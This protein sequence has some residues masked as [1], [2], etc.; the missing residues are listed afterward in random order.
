MPESISGD[1]ITIALASDKNYADGLLVTAG[2]I[3]KRANPQAKIEWVVLDG[4]ILAE[5]VELLEKVVLERH[6][7]S[8]FRRIPF[9]AETIP[10]REYH[11]SV[12]SY[13]RLYLP[14]LLP[15][16]EW[17]LY[18][19]VDFLWL[20][21]V[22]E[23]WKLRDC[24]YCVQSTVDENVLHDGGGGEKEWFESRG[25]RF[26][27]ENYFCAGLTLFNLKKLRETGLNA[28]FFAFLK[29]NQDVILADQSVMNAV[30]PP[31]GIGFLPRRWQIFANRL[32]SSDASGQFVIHYGASA[33]WY[34]M[35]LLT[36]SAM[37]WFRESADL[38]DISALS[39][40]RRSHNAAFAVFSRVVYLLATS[41]KPAFSLFR[42]FLRMVNHDGV[43]DFCCKIPQT[44]LNT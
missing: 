12:M 29:D 44:V 20:A 21:D 3:A 18:S 35:R 1:L 7:A 37:L 34:N 9:N 39:A 43:A 22:A 40:L 2:S 30:L 16:R 31:E 38:R 10:A 41:C 6:P 23:L 19:D 26:D 27:A 25:L 5:D 24:R 33:P 14:E 28:R 17:V 8:I 4:G 13:A 11:G 36:D 15:D 42:M 32:K